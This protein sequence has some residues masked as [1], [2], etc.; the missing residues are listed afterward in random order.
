MW[1]DHRNCSITILDQIALVVVP[2]KH[3]DSLALSATANGHFNPPHSRFSAT[4][5]PAAYQTYSQIVGLA[6]CGAFVVL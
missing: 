5:P 6:L 3:L 1:M 2:C 4:T